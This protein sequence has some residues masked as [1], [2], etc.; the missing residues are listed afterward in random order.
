MTSRSAAGH[1]AGALGPRRGRSARAR[2][3]SARPGSV[4]LRPVG[5]DAVHA[6][7]VAGY[8][9]LADHAGHRPLRPLVPR[10]LVPRR[11]DHHAGGVRPVAPQGA[12]PLAQRLT[13]AR[14]VVGSA[15]PPAAGPRAGGAGVGSSGS[16]SPKRHPVGSAEPLVRLRVSPSTR[17]PFNLSLPK[18][19]LRHSMRISMVLPARWGS[20]QPRLFIASFTF[21]F[22]RLQRADQAW[23]A[24]TPPARCGR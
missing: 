1:A 18:S 22:V 24:D 5:A 21:T 8:P 13:A 2:H 14:S 6:V 23:C 4:S 17:Y 11:V 9:G 7:A 20:T 15:S 3:A 12:S 19:L 10:L 16:A